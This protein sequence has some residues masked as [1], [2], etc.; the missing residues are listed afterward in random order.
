MRALVLVLALIAG[1][2]IWVQ[3]SAYR[4]ATEEAIVLAY[5]TRATDA[6]AGALR[7]A[8]LRPAAAADWARVAEARVA[9]GKPSVPV[10]FWQ[11][12][13]ELWDARFRHAYLMI[14]SGDGETCAYD[15]QADTAE[16][17]R[18]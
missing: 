7:S 11:I 16:I 2:K 3:E 6:C 12:D 15:L 1:L 5:R 17:V 4:A 18:S 8:A 9:I 10:Y 13:H 14:G